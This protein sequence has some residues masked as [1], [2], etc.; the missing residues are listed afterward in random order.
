LV[1][2]LGARPPESIWTT[3]ISVFEIRYGLQ[4]M[5]KGRRRKALQAAFERSL[6][7]DLEGRILDFDPEAAR[8]AASI[9]AKL[10]AIVRPVEIRDVLIAGVVAARRATLATRNVK[11]FAEI[12]IAISNPWDAHEL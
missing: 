11:H 1:D 3:S 6:D 12:A 9:A 5:P 10:R 7:D 8:E 4:A 2:W